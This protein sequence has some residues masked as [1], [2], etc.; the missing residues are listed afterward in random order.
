MELSIL[1]V[2]LAFLIDSESGLFAVVPLE[3]SQQGIGTRFPSTLPTFGLLVTSLRPVELSSYS[4]WWA[5]F[6]DHAL[7]LDN[8]REVC[9]IYEA[10]AAMRGRPSAARSGGE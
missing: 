8:Y 4:G 5:V 2:K 7:T 10:R 6:S 3:V 1:K 9:A